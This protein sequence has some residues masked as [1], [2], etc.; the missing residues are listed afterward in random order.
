MIRFHVSFGSITSEGLLL[1]GMIRAARSTS[2]QGSVFGF[3]LRIRGCDARAC[4]RDCEFGTWLLTRLVE[5]LEHSGFGCRFQ[6]LEAGDIST[7][8]LNFAL[9]TGSS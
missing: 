8:Q 4:L 6:G 1:G 9:F 3:L 2:R 5:G 7:Y